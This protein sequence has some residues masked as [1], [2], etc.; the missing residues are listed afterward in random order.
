MTRAGRRGH[1]RMSSNPVLL[2]LRHPLTGAPLQRLWEEAYSKAFAARFDLTVVENDCDLDALCETVKPDL[3]AF[4]GAYSALQRRI[5]VANALRHADIPRIGLYFGDGFCTTRPA[6]FHDME[7]WGADTYFTQTFY[8]A[9]NTPSVANRTFVLPQT[10]DEDLYR[11]YGEAKTT[12]FIVFGEFAAWR[13]WRG[14]TASAL[15]KRYPTMICPHPGYSASPSGMAWVGEDYARA[16]NRS[17]FSIAD[18]SVFN[19]VLRKHMEI[20]ACGAV[21]ISQ[22]IDGLAEYGFA[23]MQNCVIG[24]GPGLMARIAALL[25]KPEQ[26]RAIARAGY[27]LVHAR[28][29]SRRCDQLYRWFIERRALQPGET[30][31][32]HG[33]FG[34]FE[35]VRDGRSGAL[36]T[37]PVQANMLAQQYEDAEQNYRG[38]AL[39]ICQKKLARILEFKSEYAPARQLLVRALL[40]AGRPNDAAQHA[41]HTFNIAQR[42]YRAPEPDPVE[43]A[44]WSI[45][46]LCRGDM[47]ATGTALAAYPGL[48]HAELRRVAWLTGRLKGEPRPLPDG[49]ASEDRPSV[50]ITPLE[51][52]P[53]WLKEI[54]AMFQRCGQTRFAEAAAALANESPRPSPVQATNVYNACRR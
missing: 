31:V 13:P 8:L 42:I 44:W 19:C 53:G 34:A 28:H 20:P 3:I 9:E 27:D 49:P 25:E 2:L 52:L 47:A 18:G 26:V 43:W 32:Q 10:F 17:Q 5:T 48:R 24:E 50:A 1:M 39:S 12:P 36:R 21:L 46:H 40:M 37:Y 11:D 29:A 6:F 41:L 33:T 30:I 15:S 14:E 38:E 23:D 54:S 22:P 51:P 35:R 4:R 7:Q 45:I 16:L